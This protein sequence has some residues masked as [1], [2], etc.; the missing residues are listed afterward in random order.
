MTA[1]IVFH[2]QQTQAT[3]TNHLPMKPKRRSP[4]A[5]EVHEAILERLPAEVRPARAVPPV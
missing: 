2:S 3:L 5:T 1:D 4:I